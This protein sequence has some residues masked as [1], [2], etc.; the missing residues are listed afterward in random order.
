MDH[1]NRAYG[2]V[3]PVIRQIAPPTM[4]F[5]PFYFVS[6]VYLETVPNVTMPSVSQKYYVHKQWLARKTARKETR[7]EIEEHAIMS[8][9]F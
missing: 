3:F 7:K 1:I 6:T 5:L 4:I 9:D 8:Q 2:V